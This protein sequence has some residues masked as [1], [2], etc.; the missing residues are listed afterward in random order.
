MNTGVPLIACRQSNYNAKEGHFVVIIGLDGTDVVFHDPSQGAD[1]REGI[2]TFLAKWAY[3]G[4]QVTGG[5]AIWVSKE[6]LSRT[7]HPDQ[8]NHWTARH[9]GISVDDPAFKSA[10]VVRE[11]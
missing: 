10:L 5:V 1:Q 4:P 9:L 3:S 2:I 7:L 6:D 8:P 11:L